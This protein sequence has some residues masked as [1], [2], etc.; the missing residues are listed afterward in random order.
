MTVPKLLTKNNIMDERE[1]N[2]NAYKVILKATSIFAGV[3][4]YKI[5][6]GIINSKFIAVLL[7]A[8]GMGV[9]GLYTST[10]LLIQNFTAMG[11]SSSAV[12][13]ISE[14]NSAN[15]IK[16]VS[17][18][19]TVL[20]RLVWITGLLG[21]VATIVL[22]RWLSKT[23]FGSYDYT[24]PFISLSI[25]LL[26]LQLSNGQSA[27]LQGMRK[28][29]HLAKAGVIGSTIGLCTSIPIYYF[30][31]LKGI[32]PT[33]ILY[34]LTT[35]MSTWWFARKIKI[36]NTIITL[37]QTFNE[38][39]EM[40]KMGIALSF[41]G[42]LVYLSSFLIKIIINNNGGIK[43][44]GLYTAGFT[45]VNG[46]VGLIFNAMGTDY[47]PR[48]AAVN[49]D[50]I[51]CTEIINQQAEIAILVISPM[52]ILFLIFSQLII[53]LLY[54]N[55]FLEISGFMRWAILGIMFKSVS[56]S[57]SYQF[58]AKGE[59]R[60]FIANELIA[61]IYMLLLSILLYKNYGLDGLGIALLASYI[62]YL[63]QVYCISNRRYS[64]KFTK[65]F[66]LIYL[67]QLTLI[68]SCFLSIY[69]LNLVML[70]ILS[71]LIMSIS[72]Y[73]SYRELNSRINIK[74]IIISIKNKIR[75]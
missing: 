60:L 46:Y 55:D 8:A 24:I 19:I 23:V 61:N 37:Q 14:A 58:V 18:I 43:E 71:L 59:S 7:G 12:R 2:S 51:K 45:V 64:F 42:I 5:I 28:L 34:S 10:A 32:V 22:S 29:K 57:I 21:M 3:Q 15:D 13:N 72:L 68:I 66:K 16:Q 26:L 25:T 20:R 1:V 49:R 54:S 6:I 36:E 47:Y 56:W 70:H 74:K 30:F 38:G 62:L 63:L 48:L 39:K 67:I 35:L 9:I 73:Y 33:L 27:V 44:V 75:S 52:L 17:L 53:S 4:I 69:Y 50:D 40:L 11:L 65:T 31:G 41:N